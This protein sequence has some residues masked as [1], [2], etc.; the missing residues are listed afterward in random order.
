M[1]KRIRLTAQDR[2]AAEDKGPFPGTMNHEDR[3]D[4]KMDQYDNFTQTVN[5]ELPDMRTEWKDNPRDEMNVGI[6]DTKGPIG[7]PKGK[8]GRTA[9]EIRTAAVK[10]VRLA[11]MLLGD[12]VQKDLLE[13]QARDFYAMGDAALS[14]SLERFAKTA[15]LYETEEKTDDVD[16]EIKNASAALGTPAPVTA[17][18]P[19]AS[20]T[21]VAAPVTASAPVVAPAAAP[22]A[23]AAPVTASAKR[24][25]EFP[26]VAPEAPVAP[27]APA[28][29]API[30][31]APEQADTMEVEASATEGAN[32]QNGDTAELDIE[33]SENP[34]E[35]EESDPEA[36]AALAALFN[37]NVPTTASTEAVPTKTAKAKVGVKSLGSQPRTASTKDSAVEMDLSQLWKSA[38]DISKAFNQ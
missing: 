24:Q 3:K 27:V 19:V 12:K 23:P 33:L 26:P 20:A 22:V 10:S 1:S 30:A 4:P 15:G 13:R 35:S 28:P 25:A 32:S 6:P 8:T 29:E 17:A 21:P 16:T 36:D 38:P 11:V 9:A 14:R 18:V 34:D 2:K 5:H 31:P 7:A 37:D